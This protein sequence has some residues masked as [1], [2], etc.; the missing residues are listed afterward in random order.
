MKA[1]YTRMHIQQIPVRLISLN[2]HLVSLNYKSND[3]FHHRDSHK[4]EIGEYPYDHTQQDKARNSI[5]YFYCLAPKRE[6]VK[7]EDE[8]RESGAASECELQFK[9]QKDI[10]EE[11]EEKDPELW[12]EGVE[13]ARL[14]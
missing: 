7:L 11:V 3:P 14:K 8:G 10:D 1:R 6:N 4:H 2:G 13:L 9:Y 12:L 5:C